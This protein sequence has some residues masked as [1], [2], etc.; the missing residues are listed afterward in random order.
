MPKHIA[1]PLV[2]LVLRD[3]AEAIIEMQNIE[4]LIWVSSAC[5]KNRYT[6]KARSSIKTFKNCKI[7]ITEK[8]KVQLKHKY[9]VATKISSPDF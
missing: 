4:F 1:R 5:S 9:L 3:L 7:V 8:S 2:G 6:T